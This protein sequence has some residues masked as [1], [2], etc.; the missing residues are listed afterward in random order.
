[1]TTLAQF[2]SPRVVSG[3]LLRVAPLTGLAAAAINSVLFLVAKAAGLIPAS[4]L[5]KGQPLSVVPVI[6]SSILPVLVAAGVFVL[7]GRFSKNPVRVFTV[8]A[9]LLLLASFANPFLGIPGVTTAMA[10]VLNVMH[11]VV[12]GLVLYAFRRFATEP[13]VS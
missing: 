11:V 12:A 9:V 7:I 13:A 10:L 1:M 2:S 8:L 5:V 3:A 6:I 4:V